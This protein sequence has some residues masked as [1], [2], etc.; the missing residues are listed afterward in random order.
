MGAWLSVGPLV[1]LCPYPIPGLADVHLDS[2]SV[3]FT[4]V[5]SLV[6]AALFSVAPLVHA[7]RMNVNGGLKEGSNALVGGGRADLARSFMFVS[8]IALALMLVAG[9]GLLLRSLV[10]ALE[11]PAGFQAEGL[12]VRKMGFLSTPQFFAGLLERVQT[13]PQVSMASLVVCPPM[14]G[15]C[16]GTTYSDP[17]KAVGKGDL[18]ATNLVSSEYFRTLGTPLIAGRGFDTSDTRAVAIVNQTM[19]RRMSPEGRVLGKRVRLES[20]FQDPKIVEIVGV[21]GDV[22]QAA[23]EAP[24]KPEIYRHLMAPANE[25]RMYSTIVIRSTQGPA[26]LMG[27]VQRIVQEL[28]KGQP[29][30]QLKFYTEIMEQGLRPRKFL[31]FLLTLFG[32]LAVLLAGTG[33]FG[34]MAFTVAR[35]KREV[36]IRMA[37]GARQS[38]VLGLILR[39]GLRL[40]F[41]GTLLGLAGMWGVTRFL[42]SL[43]FGVKA[44]DPVT[45]FMAALL[46]V[47][48]SLAASLVPAWRA[49]R[50]DPVVVMR[51]N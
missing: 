14:N 44:A 26:A 35:R 9:A 30:I 45:M 19:A 43:L 7:L 24:V 31:T 40:A 32:A 11:V 18:V 21:V 23:L 51:G 4:A 6:S 25:P 48:V 5:I 22:H 17:T 20:Q 1:R 47:A 8:Q 12:M 36:A 15:G 29:A 42:E 49:A 46:L 50:V 27:T 16:G 13:L 37:L 41:A 38:N 34:V 33:V 10:A 3:A 2:R 39:Q 28:D